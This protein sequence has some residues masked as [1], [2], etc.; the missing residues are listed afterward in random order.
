MSA[1]HPEDFLSAAPNGTLALA[2]AAHVYSIVYAYIVLHERMKWGPRNPEC[3][4]VTRQVRDESIQK[5]Y[6]RKEAATDYRYAHQQEQR[7]FAS[8]V[9]SRC[10][11]KLS[12]NQRPASHQAR[13]RLP[14][15]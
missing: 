5:A 2:F 12:A 15:R 8:T 10:T 14:R 4:W 3:T 1:P 6:R 13:K 9:S 11:E 7:G